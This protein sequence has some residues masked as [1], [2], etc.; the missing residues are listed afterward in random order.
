MENFLLRLV[1]TIS[2]TTYPR[3]QGHLRNGE[4]FPSLGSE[5]QLLEQMHHLVYRWAMQ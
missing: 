3:N 5:C 2:P 4:R 1:R